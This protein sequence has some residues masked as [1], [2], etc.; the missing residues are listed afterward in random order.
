MKKIMIGNSKG[1]TGKSVSS[2]SLSHALAIQKQ[3][4]L[5][6]DADP[7]GNSSNWLEP[8]DIEYELA[9]VIGGKTTFEKA[10]V[11]ASQGFDMVV[12]FPD[13]DLRGE[14][15]SELPKKPFLFEDFFSKIENE[16]DYLIVDTSPS[17]SPLERSVCI[18]VDEVICPVELE[19][20]AVDG[21]G[22]FDKNIQNLNENWRKNIKL[23]KI[24]L[25][26]ENKSY[27]R[28]KLLLEILKKKKGYSFFTVRQDALMA[29]CIGLN[30]TIFDRDRRAKSAVDYMKIAQGII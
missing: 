26:K 28:H 24:I 19:F 20:F 11:K 17:F 13:G 16:Y 23:D 18:A 8:S 15:E 22:Q 2:V 27:S 25:T 6:V 21:L 4:V 1:G 30:K 12:T 3:R 7:Q 5:L 9:D 10:I 14:S 29:E